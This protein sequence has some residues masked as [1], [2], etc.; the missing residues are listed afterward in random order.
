M[1]ARDTR[2]QDRCLLV[3]VQLG[4]MRNPEPCLS[5]GRFENSTSALALLT[6]HQQPRRGEIGKE[7]MLS[8]PIFPITWGSRHHT[9]LCIVCSASEVCISNWVGLTLS[10]PAERAKVPLVL[11]TPGV[12]SDAYTLS[13]FLRQTMHQSNITEKST[14]IK[15]CASLS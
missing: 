2:L 1:T 10:I 13:S 8:S 9:A 5:L 14:V 12:W 15:E 4:L 3:S 6:Y 11:E 7:T